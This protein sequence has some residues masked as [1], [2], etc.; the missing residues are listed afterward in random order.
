[1]INLIRLVKLRPESAFCVKIRVILVCVKWGHTDGYTK[2]HIGASTLTYRNLAEFFVVW[3]SLFVCRF[4]EQAFLSDN[5]QRVCYS[6]SPFA[7][8][9]QISLYR[10][11]GF[12]PAAPPYLEEAVQTL[13]PSY[14]RGVLDVAS[15]DI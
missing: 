13:L 8:S 1:M 11:N 12:M 7:V 14:C 5:Q 2:E 4:C 10:R 3:F 15:N 9:E 6:I